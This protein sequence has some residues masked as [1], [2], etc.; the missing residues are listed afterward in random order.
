MN[1]LQSAKRNNRLTIIALVILF[2]SPVLLATIMH[3]QWWSYRPVTTKNHG[4][5]LEPPMAIEGWQKRDTDDHKPIWTIATLSPD[6]CQSDCQEQLGWLR[7]VR[8][9][10]GRH[11]QQVQLTLVTAADITAEQQ[12]A[13]NAVST[14]ITIVNQTQSPALFEALSSAAEGVKLPVT[15][16]IDPAGF[17]ILR[18][19]AGSDATGMRKDIGR[20]ITWTNKTLGA[21]TEGKRDQ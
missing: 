16:I 15:F 17:I 21:I 10:Q 14:A 1:N 2:V 4:Q 9:A 8:A 20:L 13:V 19:A 7:Q 5:L 12:A 3:S 6:N 18:Y 11:R